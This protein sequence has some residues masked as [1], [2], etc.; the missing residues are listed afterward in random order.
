MD[1]RGARGRGGVVSGGGKNTQRRFSARGQRALCLRLRGPQLLEHRRQRAVLVDDGVHVGVLLPAGSPC[2][3]AWQQYLIHKTG[4]WKPRPLRVAAV[5]RR[6]SFAATQLSFYTLHSDPRLALTVP[7]GTAGYS[8]GDIQLPSYQATLNIKI[9]VVGSLVQQ[10][11]AVLL[12]ATMP[13][14]SRQS[15]EPRPPQDHGASGRSS[16]SSLLSTAA[17]SST[18]RWCGD[19]SSRSTQKTE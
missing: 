19:R 7:L 14:S 1:A 3:R 9:R 11:R 8:S 16:G 2:A 17:C 18:I 4:I 13:S 15:H 10:P 12:V 5:W 6:V